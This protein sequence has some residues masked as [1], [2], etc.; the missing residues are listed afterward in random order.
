MTITIEI[1]DEAAQRL[2]NLLGPAEASADALSD[3]SGSMPFSLRECGV[4]VE[5]IGGVIGIVNSL[6]SGKLPDPQNDDDEDYDDDD[7]Q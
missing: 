4:D 2:S 1:T 6:F 5:A 7:D 3:F